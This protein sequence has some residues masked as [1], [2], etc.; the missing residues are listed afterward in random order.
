M[1]VRIRLFAGLRERA[2]ADEVVLEGLAE[3]STIADL[4]AEL[5]RR[6]PELGDLTGVAGVVGTTY[7]PPSRVV[8]VGDVVALLP[9]VSGG[10]PPRDGATPEDAAAVSDDAALRAG[11]FELSEAP[12]DPGALHARLVHPTAGAVVLF[13]GTTRA[14]NRGQA[15]TRLE[16]EAFHAFAVPEMARIF[17]E[18]SAQFGDGSPLADPA[19]ALARPGARTLR[20]LCVHRVGTV[21]VAEPSVVIGVS[22][23]HRDT[24]FRAARF[25]IDSLKERLPVWKKEVY[26]NG[27]HWIGERS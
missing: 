8:V 12:L 18:C 24:A 7:V 2:G 14:S 25:L 20:M 26:G 13:T 3:G 16:Y 15:V 1:Q 19:G 9:P 4:K 27:H 21:G 17:A 6:R 10:A 22:S 5:A 23:P 11:L